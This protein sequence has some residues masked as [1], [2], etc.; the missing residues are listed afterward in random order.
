[1]RYD[2]AHKARSRARILE[3]A[4]AR[5][6]RDGFEGAS[7]DQV[8][9]DAGLTRGAFY[10][11][12][13]SKAALVREV[14]GIESGLVGSLRA[15]DADGVLAVLEAY[16]APEARQDVARGCPLVA[17]PVDVIRSDASAREGY[18]ERVQAFVHA[19]GEARPDLS[20]DAVL[21]VVLLAIS[22]GLVSA[23]MAESGLADRIG[24]VALG[25][26]RRLLVGQ[27]SK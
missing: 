26:I 21:Q 7:I 16:L 2:T 22:G 12:F 19:L 1:M 20:E 9:R 23:A 15:T 11:H 3:A 27:S 4:R 14:L 24:E 18:T 8:M 13:A 6:R 10:A 17:H 5:F 25:Q